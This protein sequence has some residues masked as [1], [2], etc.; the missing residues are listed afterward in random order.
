MALVWLLVVATA[1]EGL[2]CLTFYRKRYAF[3]KRWLRSALLAGALGVVP[4][5]LLAVYVRV[6]PLE[7]PF[8][9]TQLPGSVVIDAHG[10]V[11]QRETGD[12]L[13]IPVALDEIAPVLLQATIAAEDQRFRSHGGIDPFAI[14]RAII[15][16]P[17]QRSG[18]S[19]LTQQLAR[20][21][22]ID[23]STP[24][25][26]RK[27]REALIALQLEA[28]YSKDEILSLYLNEIY[29]GRGAYGVEA[30]AR[31]YFGVSA[32]HLDLAQAAFL[33]G[34]PQ[35]P[36]EMGESVDS[37]EVTER[38]RYVLRRLED[39]GRISGREA[40]AAAS[41]KLEFV[42]AP[43][44]AVA[45]HFVQYVMAELARIGPDLES[46]RGLVIE[47]TL[48]SGLQ[49][50]A[51]RQVAFQLAAL[52]DKDVG[53]AA[54]VVLE[55]SSGQ[56][57]AMVGSAAFQDES[58]SGQ[59]NM[60]LV[61][62]Q[63]GSAL[64]PF[65]YAVALEK[66]FTAASMLLD[67][68]TNF[69]AD[70]SLYQPLNYDR[71]FHGPVSLR[72]AL[73]SSLNVPAVR[74]LD[75]IGIDTF[76]EMA[77]RFGLETLTD[78]EVYGLAL[79]L[80]GGEVTLLDLTSAYATLANEGL[81]HSPYAIERI[82]DADGSILYEHT[83]PQPVRVLSEQHAFVLA[84]I[85]S[86][87][88]ARELG[89]GYAP[90]LRLAYP[91]AVKTGTTTESRDNW[92]LGF[93]PERAVGVWVGNADNTPMRNISG[94]QGAGPIWHG[95][96]EAAMTGLTSHWPEPPQGLSRVTVCAPTGLLPGPFCPTP[97]QEWFVARSEPVD[98]ETYYARD[99][100]GRL[101]V[102]P[103]DEARSWAMA[104]GLELGQGAGLGG[105]AFLVQPGPGSVLFLS[106]ELA[107]QSVLLKASPPSG[108]QRVE[109]LVDGTLAAVVSPS[110]ASTV[111]HLVAGPHLLEVRAV[112]SDGRVI[113]ATSRFEVR[114]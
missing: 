39:T 17:F 15:Q 38:Q 24:L 36:V 101:V 95:V 65:L 57:L 91:A 100:S 104:A 35:R 110:S 76:L 83:A 74:T 64:K 72:V 7:S 56:V 45:P 90:T 89:F 19:T 109:F 59:I 87:S 78:V 28:R 112:L 25:L 16:L 84:D 33:A 46:R 5:A 98:T 75:E 85:L 14:G 102:N 41:E 96:M 103:P 40:N 49:S 69:D 23:D 18:A 50:D 63:P 54:V 60:A 4:V 31:L 29:Y 82:L 73:A 48:D 80:G 51:E 61:P 32:A 108:T 6:A 106:P 55:P 53:N 27:A 58:A 114:R 107:S 43:S 79:T 34:L 42:K 47:T 99:A 97:T 30:A 70:G 113:S 62:R 2:I 67:V 88:E 13:R 21:L 77:H 12:G 52:E 26:E 111:W 9:R 22:Y 20:R 81:L 105:S 1:L 94:I 93:T 3:A 44:Q 71:R 8:M 66:G 11:L 92:T 86:D 10:V 68:Q 37:P